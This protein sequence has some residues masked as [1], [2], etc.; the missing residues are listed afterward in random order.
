MKIYI[1]PIYRQDFIDTPNRLLYILTV[2]NECL[3]N[4]SPFYFKLGDSHEIHRT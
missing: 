1:A 3:I 2:N 4:W